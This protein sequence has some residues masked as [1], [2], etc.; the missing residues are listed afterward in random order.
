MDHIPDS[1]LKDVALAEKAA[2]SAF[3]S[4]SNTSIKKTK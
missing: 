1:D 2:Q 3:P 4:W